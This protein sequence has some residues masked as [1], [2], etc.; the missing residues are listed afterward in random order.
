MGNARR[1]VQAGPKLGLLEIAV[2]VITV[3]VL[4]QAPNRLACVI[5]LGSL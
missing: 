4:C 2:F 5:G 3:T 1:K